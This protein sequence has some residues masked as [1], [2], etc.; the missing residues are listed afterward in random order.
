MENALITHPKVGV[1][2][3]LM[4]NLETFETQ[5]QVSVPVR[6]LGSSER[7]LQICLGTIGLCTPVAIS[8]SVVKMKEEFPSTFV[9]NFCCFR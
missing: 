5:I 4:E 3:A 8:H 1:F 9:R 2:P 6:P 7:M